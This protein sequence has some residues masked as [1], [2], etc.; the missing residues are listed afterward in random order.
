MS[1]GDASR[2]CIQSNRPRFRSFDITAST[3]AFQIMLAASIYDLATILRRTFGLP[4][5]L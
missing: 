2:S 1:I 4:R 3:A 5:S